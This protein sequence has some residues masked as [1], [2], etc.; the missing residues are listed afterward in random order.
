M[1]WFR[2]IAILLSP[3]WELHCGVSRD[4]DG[5]RYVVAARHA[6]KGTAVLW[7]G[8]GR[9]WFMPSLLPIA[10]HAD[11]HVTPVL[12]VAEQMHGID[13]EQWIDRNEARVIP[14]GF[15]SD[16]VVNEW[17][18][19][20]DT[21][22]S[23]TATKEAVAEAAAFCTNEN[24]FLES[25]AAPLWDLA[26]LYSKKLSGPFVL[27]CVWDQG[28]V[29]GLVKNGRLHALASFWATSDEMR[30]KQAE[31]GNEASRL[32]KS[33]AQDTGATSVVVAGVAENTLKE[34]HIEGYT[35]SGPPAV[36][37]VSPEFHHGFALAQH[38]HTHV[39]F[40]PFG[41]A[42]AAQRLRQRRTR[43]LRCLQVAVL[44]ACGLAGLMGLSG[45]AIAAGTAMLAQRIEPLRE[46][47]LQLER[48]ETRLK[49]L[50]ASLSARSALTARES[51]VT[52]FLN[53]LQEVFPEGAWAEQIAASEAD[54]SG[55][56]V[57]ITAVAYSTALIPE[58]M[59]RLSAAPGVSSVRMQYSEQG[60]E[61]KGERGK[62]VVRCKIGC[63]WD[64]SR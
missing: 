28:S 27:W 32:I 39:D 52:L 9:P 37:G 42:R 30:S 11:T 17:A 31:V 35:V 25:L 49:A 48:Q 22:Y 13:A 44:A 24:L 1:T 36:H 8:G 58:I 62:R 14:R 47:L 51:A 53:E 38:E 41:Q 7:T 63:V 3:K 50:R 59:Q 54:G 33:L 40:A 60:H 5:L 61:R 21:L 55:F 2:T 46:R 19:V 16:E 18:T 57:Q 56:S 26:R 6:S 64:S 20:D 29:L 10:V 23:V 45:G 4:G 34:L 12:L 15:T 43:V